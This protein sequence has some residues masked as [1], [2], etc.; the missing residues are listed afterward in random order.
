MF[1]SAISFFQ[2]HI[3]VHTDERPYKCRF[4]TKSFRRQ[5]TRTEHERIH[6][7]EKPYKCSKCGWAFAKKGNLQDH[8]NFCS[9]QRPHECS[10][11][12]QSFTRKAS[13]R[14]HEKICLRKNDQSEPS[15]EYLESEI[16][17]NHL[18]SN[19][20]SVIE[21]EI[22]NE[23]ESLEEN[24]VTYKCKSSLSQNG[25]LV[26]DANENQTDIRNPETVPIPDKSLSYK[27]NEHQDPNFATN[28][29]SLSNLPNLQNDD[30]NVGPF[31]CHVCRKS[32]NSRQNLKV[33]LI[34][35]FIL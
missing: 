16:A 11:C 8:E 32:F 12:K 18:L 3:R 33:S 14:M 20:N 1:Y 15:E 28:H 23:V 10:F 13:C 22:E 19:M 2:R 26:Q 6:T 34:L 31:T 7:G 4:C 21:E 24:S 35:H 17:S 27:Q 9:G 25:S 29:N 5:H 30:V